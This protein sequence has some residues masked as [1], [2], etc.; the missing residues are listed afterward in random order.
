MVYGLPQL[1]F[2]NYTINQSGSRYVLIAG[3]GA[4]IQIR[5]RPNDRETRL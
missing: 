1:V 3:N 2:S 4:Y 5:L